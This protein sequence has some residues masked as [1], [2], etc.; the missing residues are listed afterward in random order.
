MKKPLLY[1]ILLCFFVIQ[2]GK[3]Q[4]SFQHFSRA[5]GLPEDGIN[6]IDRD[7]RGFL[8]LGT[9]QGIVRFDGSEMVQFKHRSTDSL[10]LPASEI[11]DI[12]ASERGEIY[13]G[14]QNNGVVIFDIYSLETEHIP[15]K[16]EGRLG[17]TS[18]QNLLLTEDVHSLW[19]SCSYTGVDRYFFDSDSIVNY[20]PGEQLSHLNPRMIN[21]FTCGTI[22]PADMDILW[23]GTLQG[24]IRFNTTSEQFTHFPL[25]RSECENRQLWGGREEIIRDLLFIS[26][27]QLYFASW[28]GG[29]GCLNIEDGRYTTFKYEKVQPV[30]GRKNNI[31]KIL[32]KSDHEIWF[33]AQHESLGIFDM[34][35]ASFSF[36]T[37]SNDSD[38]A[39]RNPSDLCAS[40]DGNLFVASYSEGLSW[41]NTQAAI[42]NFHPLPYALISGKVIY[43]SVL[44]AGTHGEHGDLIKVN[45]NNHTLQQFKYQAVDDMGDNFFTGIP[46]ADAQN[47]W[48]VESFNLYAFDLQTHSIQPYP[49]FNPYDWVINKDPHHFFRCSTMDF[50][51]NIWIGSTFNGLFKINPLTHEIRNFYF[52]DAA[53]HQPLLDEFIFSLF[54][55]SDG[56]IWYG[57][58]SCGTIDPETHQFT[59]LQQLSDTHGK[60]INT[61]NVLAFTE[62]SDHQIWLGTENAGIHVIQKQ[63][64]AY[65]WQ[66]SF[67]E[68][69]GLP[70]NQVWA[71][72]RD[73]EDHVWVVCDGFLSRIFPETGKIENYGKAYGIEQIYFLD[74]LKDGSIIAGSG[75]GYYHFHPDDI[76]PLNIQPKLYLKSFKIFDRAVPL[77]DIQKGV[78]VMKL[79]YDQNFFSIEYGLIDFLKE[80]EPDYGYMLEGLDETWQKAGERTYISYTNL[81]GGTYRLK[82]KEKRADTLVL[83]LYIETPFWKTIWFFSLIILCILGLALMIH[84]YRLKQIR[85]Q[86]KTKEDFNRK[87]NEL[88]IKALRAQMNPHFL[89]NSLNSIRYY[90]LKKE[91]DNAADY[92]T[93][94]SRLLRLILKNSRQNQISLQ[95]ELHALE[96]Y[97]EFEQMRFNNKFDY[98]VKIQDG[99]DISKIQVQPLTLQPF[100]ENAIW[101][102]LMPKKEQGKLSVEVEK[103]N[104]QL[105]VTITDNGVGRKQAEVQNDN[106]VEESKSFGLKITEDRMHLMES[107][108]GKR[109]DFKVID[110]FENRK[111]AGTRVIITFEI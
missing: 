22:D 110:L 86:Q 61:G 75:H 103:N 59:E 50:S 88:E 102:G 101:H 45:L 83:P 43:D 4:F 78:D 104:Q 109:S 1:I 47:A 74:I 15:L 19:I 17:L 26:D 46:G 89:F 13:A 94:F 72:L 25:G 31:K 82:I 108:R 6:C 3:S 99:L 10:S 2:S 34:E 12:Y 107:I 58:K 41:T 111:P 91:N 70:S 64:D 51:G 87:I 20:Q 69:D 28:G 79:G 5:D 60:K 29:L 53:L 63:S 35:T 80:G 30:N 11:L 49:Y 8:W 95:D 62:T 106:I 84:R 44:L 66:A 40:M 23:F 18:G 7:D 81:E 90:I 38:I 85:Q 37:N 73:S 77:V 76:H 71:M 105:V 9:N 48:L 27:T 67:T 16:K 54:T 97:M 56:H 42:F 98:Q 36:V 65:K 55:D 21:T 57:T 68:Q 96:I 93:K 24:I 92:I 14:T 39:V 100:V 33:A 52:E 32:L